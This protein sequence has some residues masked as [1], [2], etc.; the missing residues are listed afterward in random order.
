MS[1]TRRRFLQGFTIG[2]AGLVGFF[3]PSK[4]LA[5]FRRR[6][7]CY[8]GTVPVLNETG[9][10]PK[11]AYGPI[12]INYPVAGSSSNLTQVPGGGYFFAWGTKDSNVGLTGAKVTG[13]SADVSGHY[14]GGPNPTTQWG[15]W[16]N[17]VD[18]YKPLT[19]TVSG[20]TTS[21]TPV[22]SMVGNFEC[23]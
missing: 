13:G 12:N 18:T 3:A 16:F 9:F 15:Y 23:V 2:L 21:M 4:C 11:T 17:G 6:R 20:M 8:S 14:V 22:S 1:A 5:W 10:V 7:R 19:L